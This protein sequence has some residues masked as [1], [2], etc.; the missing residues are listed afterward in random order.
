VNLRRW[1]RYTADENL[2]IN[3][4][5]A[6]VLI[7]PTYWQFTPLQNI[8]VRKDCSL[9]VECELTLFF[10]TLKFCCELCRAF[11]C[12]EGYIS[13]KFVCGTLESSMWLIFQLAS[14]IMRVVFRQTYVYGHICRKWQMKLKIAWGIWMSVRQDGEW[15][16]T[17][18]REVNFLRIMNSTYLIALD[19]IRSGCFNV[20]L[21]IKS[22]DDSAPLPFLFNPEG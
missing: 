5:N 15:S 3:P 12:W 9:K 19:I 17:R 8:L 7:Q 1:S 22:P 10:K 21:T 2:W 20:G 14:N 13:L 6:V 18:R 11:S 16:L 4:A